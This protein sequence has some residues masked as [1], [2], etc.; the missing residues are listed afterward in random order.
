VDFHFTPGDAPLLVSMPHV[1]TAIPAAIAARMTPAALQVADT[2]WHLAELYGFAARMGAST[3]A[4]HWSRYVIDLNR[5]PQDSNLYPGLD[6][7]GLCPLDTFD[8]APLY[9]P[10]QQPDAADTAQRLSDYWQPYH[11]QLQA[12]LDR[13]LARHGKVVLWEAHSIASLV[14]R[15]FD[16]KLPDLNF[17]SASGTSCAPALEAAVLTQAEAHPRYTLAVNGRFKGG[18]ITRQYGQPEQ[19]VH[20]LQLEMCQSLYM[21]EA[22]P[23]G[24]RPDLA[25]HVQIPLRDMLHAALAWVR[26]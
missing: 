1:G 19:G 14:P 5:P 25:A 20:A 9:L 16:G 13:L 8:R 17:G 11:T 18:H 21:D 12:E 4:A 26:Q 6:T 7:T 23:F 3:L 2:D 22:A 24:Y 10:G 15:F